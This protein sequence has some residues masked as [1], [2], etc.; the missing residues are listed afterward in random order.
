MDIRS[1]AFAI[2]TAATGVRGNLPGIR[3]C[4]LNTAMIGELACR[5]VQD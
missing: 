3:N 2:T 4:Q 5:P 1:I